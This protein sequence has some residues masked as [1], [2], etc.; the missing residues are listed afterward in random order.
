MTAA[1]LEH[2]GFSNDHSFTQ[3]NVITATLTDM[4]FNVSW[5]GVMDQLIFPFYQKR[6]RERDRNGVSELERNFLF[7][8]YS[9][10]ECLPK[11]LIIHPPLLEQCS[12]AC[13]S[14]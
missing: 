3:I 5:K 9:T 2:P 12:K 6:Q 1:T 7:T 8:A 14:R 10:F 4:S 13:W 11:K